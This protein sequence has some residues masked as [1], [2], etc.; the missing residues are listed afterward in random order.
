MAPLGWMAATQSSP[1]SVPPPAGGLISYSIYLEKKSKHLGH[2]KGEHDWVV[3]QREEALGSS[4]LL[5]CRT[6]LAWQ[7]S[8]TYREHPR[9]LVPLGQSLLPSVPK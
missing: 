2:F 9:L 7:R 3:G 4:C 6:V 1:F 8:G 5:L